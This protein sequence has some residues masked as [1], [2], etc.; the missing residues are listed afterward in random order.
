ML[1]LCTDSTWIFGD[2]GHDKAAA[3]LSER[4]DA[5][6]QLLLAMHWDTFLM[7]YIYPVIIFIIQ[8]FNI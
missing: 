6:S 8:L 3:K 4:P 2:P 1:E 5:I 7:A